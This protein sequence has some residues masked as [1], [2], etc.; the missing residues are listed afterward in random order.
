[1]S[2]VGN[3]IQLAL[4][5]SDFFLII[6]LIIF[7][8]KEGYLNLASALLFIFILSFKHGFVRQDNHVEIFATIV[9]LITSLLILKI[10][11]IHYQRI[12]YCFFA[13][14]LCASF[15]MLPVVKEYSEKLTATQV[16]NNLNFLL[17]TKKLQLKLDKETRNELAQVQLPNNVKNLVCGKQIDIIP[18]EISLAPANQLNWQPRQGKRVSNPIDRGIIVWSLSLRQPQPTQK[19][20][21]DRS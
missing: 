16:I 7:I 8:I 4:A 6:C 9:P 14:I 3:K 13:Y 1:M 11:R 18:W 19:A 2:L 21:T 12:A 15:F 20:Y 17:N 10:S 5:I